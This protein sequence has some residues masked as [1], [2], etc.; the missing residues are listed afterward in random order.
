MFIRKS[1]LLD[2]GFFDEKIP[3]FEETELGIRL[4]KKYKFVLIDEF[5]I[6]STMNHE[7]N[8]SSP[9]IAHNKG[10][11][12]IYEKHKDVLTRS[13]CYNICN[14]I[15]GESIVKGNHKKV[16]IYLAK[17]LKHKPYKLK[18]I[19][20]FVLTS[21]APQINQALYIKKYKNDIFPFI[22]ILIQSICTIDDL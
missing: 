22:S 8:T 2:V 13:F 7:Q 14:I 19:I 4:A 10:L 18:T 15:A 17:A 5:L 21:F 9:D 16:K 6:I 12:I 20:S 3:Y 11:E 1:A